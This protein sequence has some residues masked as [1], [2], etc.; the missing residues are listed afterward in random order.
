M[1]IAILSLC[2]HFFGPLFTKLVLA[3][4][5]R[6]KVDS[7]FGLV[8]VT[9]RTNEGFGFWQSGNQSGFEMFNGQV[10]G[11]VILGRNVAKGATGYA[12]RAGTRWG[13]AP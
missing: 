13:V 1:T 11:F 12:A 10:I 7:G 4:V 9:F 2:K 8:C 5:M 3:K 6:P